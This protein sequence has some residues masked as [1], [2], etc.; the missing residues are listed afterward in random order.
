MTPFQNRS[1][2]R[3]PNPHWTGK[4]GSVAES[5]NGLPRPGQRLSKARILTVD[6]LSSQGNMPRTPA[7]FVLSPT[8][9]LPLRLQDA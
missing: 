5:T 4:R 3:S 7:I 6:R 1:F 8:I 9:W 2:A